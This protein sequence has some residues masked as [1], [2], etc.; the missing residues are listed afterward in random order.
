MRPACLGVK[1]VHGGTRWASIILRARRPTL[2]PPP[3]NCHSPVRRHA[4]RVALRGWT[5]WAEEIRETP[6]LFILSKFSTGT[7]KKGSRPPCRRRGPP[8]PESTRPFPACPPVSRVSDP[9][10]ASGVVLF[11]MVGGAS[12]TLRSQRKLPSLRS[13]SSPASGARGQDAPPTTQPPAE[14]KRLK[15]HPPRHKSGRADS[16]SGGRRAVGAVFR[17]PSLTAP[18]A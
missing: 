2:Q 12:A 6:I 7:L 8:P 4:V 16:V 17:G 18:Q 3:Q 15:Y 10:A 5:G 13:T 11:R 9:A 1:P 14:G